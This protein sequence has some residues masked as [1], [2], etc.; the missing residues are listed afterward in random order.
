[1]VLLL[2]WGNVTVAG[3][4]LPQHNIIRQLVEWHYL[5]ASRWRSQV[6]Y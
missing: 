4:M 2:I 6:P 1:M 5:V 3:I